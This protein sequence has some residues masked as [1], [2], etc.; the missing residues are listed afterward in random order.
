LQRGQKLRSR[1][2]VNTG[3]MLCGRSFQLLGRIAYFVLAAHLL[4]PS[5]YGIYVACTALC[6]AISPFAVLGTADVMTKYA[7]RDRST[8][9]MYFGNAIVVTLVSGF[10]LTLLALLVRPRILPANATSSMLILVAIAEFAGT[11]LTAI[12]AQAFLALEQA[13]NYAL[14]LTWTTALRV[15]AAVALLFSRRT[16]LSWA[17]LYAAA[18]VIATV[19]GIIAVS[20]LCSRPK[21]QG[22]CLV[23]SVREGV[24]FATAAAS[25]FVYDDIDKVML[26]RL[27]SVEAAAI[28]AVAYRFVEGAMLPIYSLASATYPEFFRRGLRGVTSAFGL[29]RSIVRRSAVYGLVVSLCLFFAAQWVPLIMGPAYAESTVALRYLSVLPLI[30]SVHAFLTDTLTGANFQWERSS[31]QMLAALFNILINLWLIRR[32]AFRGAAWSSL[33]TDTLLMLLLYLIIQWHLRRERSS[34][35]VRADTMLLMGEE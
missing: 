10:L 34:S 8:V 21:V 9:G 7:A 26:A 22:K 32:F 4:G 33:M 6:T 30:K 29:A 11:Q 19:T 3:Y 13:N 1:I 28:Y 18:G 12:C 17:C 27:S 20:R 23:A 35:A 15:L 24:H 5:A 16:A 14:I 25:Q 31:A 2:L